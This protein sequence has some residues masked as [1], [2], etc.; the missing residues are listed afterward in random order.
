MIH[1][2]FST[3]EF[4]FSYWTNFYVKKDWGK[5]EPKDDASSRLLPQQ[6][7]YSML[8]LVRVA[9]VSLGMV[10]VSKPLFKAA[11]VCSLLTPQG[12][13]IVLAE[14][15]IQPEAL[16]ALGSELRPIDFDTITREDGSKQL[17]YIRDGRFIFT[18]VIPN[19]LR[20][21]DRE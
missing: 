5:R 7:V 15:F 3:V 16:V 14:G 13:F 1:R 8:I 17:T 11:F 20:P 12:S 2:S 18:Q 21:M 4:W 9:A 6:P 10:T 19:P